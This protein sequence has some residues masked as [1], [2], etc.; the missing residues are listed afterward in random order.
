MA[1]LNTQRVIVLVDHSLPTFNTA[2]TARLSVAR[3]PRFWCRTSAWNTW[4]HCWKAERLKVTGWK[5]KTGHGKYGLDFLDAQKHWFLKLGWDSKHSKPLSSQ[6]RQPRSWKSIPSGDPSP[7]K[8]PSGKLLT[9]SWKTG[10]L[11]GLEA[12]SPSALVK[13]QL[14][15]DQNSCKRAITTASSY[16]LVNIQKPME[17]HNFQWVNPL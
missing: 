12:P 17:N 3:E 2:S 11:G 6:P 7:K 5:K 16:P 1:M 4:R 9:P 14:W 8:Q 15:L 13:S 10:N